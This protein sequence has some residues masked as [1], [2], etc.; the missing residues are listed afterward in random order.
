MPH[1]RIATG[2]DRLWKL[3]LVGVVVRRAA[4]T[5]RRAAEVAVLA[6]GEHE[7]VDHLQCVVIEV[8]RMQCAHAAYAVQMGGTCE[9]GVSRSPP[10]LR[11]SSRRG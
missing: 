8:V 9:L 11:W 10:T 1:R 2:Y 5:A 4:P 3:D 6:T 7:A